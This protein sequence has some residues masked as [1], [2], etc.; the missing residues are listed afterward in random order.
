MIELA[1][2]SKSFNESGKHIHLFDNLSLSINEP[3]V[4][5][6]IGKSGSGKTT[7]LSVL[8]GLDDVDKGSLKIGGVDIANLSED[9]LTQY[10]RHNIGI[11]FQNFHLLPFLTVKENIS[12]PLEMVG[13]QDTED[14]VAQMLNLLGLSDRA[15]HYPSMLSGGEKQRVA[16]GRAFIK[17]PKIILADEPTGNLDYETGELIAGHLIK[18]AKEEKQ[19]LVI[20]T[21]DRDLAKKCDK[22]FELKN[23]DLSQL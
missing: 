12:L 13:A 23:K 4:Y 5:A 10:R 2:I 11:V 21:H 18:L 6:I 19:T 16:I 7:L 1:N 9:E 8:G 22:V 17:K 14:K 20:V 15:G 3:G